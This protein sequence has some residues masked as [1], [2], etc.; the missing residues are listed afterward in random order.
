MLM[1]RVLLRS[2]FMCS[3]GSCHDRVAHTQGPA[4]DY[5]V[6]VAVT[7]E[8]F[9]DMDSSKTAAQVR[10]SVHVHPMSLHSGEEL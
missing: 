1:L 10:Q 3:C 9:N 6:A 5:G 8:N 4:N 2:V 7:S